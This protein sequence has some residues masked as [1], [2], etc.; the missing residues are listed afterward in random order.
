MRRTRCGTSAQARRHEGPGRVG[1]RDSSKP[2]PSPAA[3]PTPTDTAPPT[4]ST[5]TTSTAAFSS[6]KAWRS[7]KRLVKEHRG[8]IATVGATAGRMVPG[9][10]SASCGALQA[11]AWGVRSQQRG[12]AGRWLPSDGARVSARWHLLGSF[13]WVG[14]AFRSLKYV[15]LPDPR[16][17]SS[18]SHTSHW[19]SLNR[20]RA[21]RWTIKVGGVADYGSAYGAYRATSCRYRPRSCN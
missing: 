13:V 5:A 1:G 6:R 3:T 19:E 16:F 18:R 8:A 14:S 9:V 20:T 4:P 10:G 7:T 15:V 21:R 17:V 11:G 2:T 12:L